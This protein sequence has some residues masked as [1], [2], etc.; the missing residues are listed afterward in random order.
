MR[1]AAALLA[2]LAVVALAAPARAGDVD[3]AP[4]NA[5][6]WMTVPSTRHATPWGLLDL[7]RSLAGQQPAW[8]HADSL[9]GS[10]GGWR[11]RLA[12]E[13]GLALAGAYT[14]Q[15]AGN[16][17]GGRNHGVR[18]TQNVGLAFLADLGKL[19]GWDDT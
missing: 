19:A 13:Y 4:D 17:V 16:P 15:V 8:D 18:Y 6:P 5:T 1:P 14:A 7:D 2:C 10:W 11:N 9:T 3:R 12:D